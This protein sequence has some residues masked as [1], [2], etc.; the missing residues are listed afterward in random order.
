MP[1]HL[2]EVLAPDRHDPPAPGMVEP[3]KVAPRGHDFPPIGLRPGRSR[4][5]SS[6]LLFLIALLLAAL[7]AFAVG[8]SRST[9]APYGLARNGESWRA[10]MATSMRSILRR[11][12]PHSSSVAAPRLRADLFP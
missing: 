2:E 10:A 6:A 12:R 3:R 1:D 7:V 9:L 8:S 11:L 5:A 4:C